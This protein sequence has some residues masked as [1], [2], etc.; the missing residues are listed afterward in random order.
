MSKR[1]FKGKQQTDD[2]F[3]VEK[4][5]TVLGKEEIVVKYQGE[6][7]SDGKVD[8][9]L[10][11]ND[12]VRRTIEQMHE[13]Q[14]DRERRGNT[15]SFDKDHP[16]AFVADKNDAQYD[17]NGRPLPDLSKIHDEPQGEGYV[18]RSWRRFM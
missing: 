9:A 7:I 6:V 18:P 4:H 11:A 13:D 5:E 12:K 16:N 17:A 8:E 3:E 14:I 15:K 2:G 1:L 10:S